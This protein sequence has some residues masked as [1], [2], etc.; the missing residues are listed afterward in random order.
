MTEYPGRYFK[1]EV[2]T[3]YASP[4]VGADTRVVRV[5]QGLSF[6]IA[7]VKGTAIQQEL[8]TRYN[9]GHYISFVDYDVPLETLLKPDSWNP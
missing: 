8:E 9:M 6:P 7:A 3:R 5:Y 1:P 4:A 2:A